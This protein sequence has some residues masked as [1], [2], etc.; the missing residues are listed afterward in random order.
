VKWRGG[1][2]GGFGARKNKP[3]LQML[4]AKR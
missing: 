4:G 1:R 3:F 2:G